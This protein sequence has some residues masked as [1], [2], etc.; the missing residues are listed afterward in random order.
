[1]SFLNDINKNILNIME[2]KEGGKER[3]NSHWEIN[4]FLTARQRTEK[5]SSI[6]FQAV[7][8]VPHSILRKI[9]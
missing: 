2:Y 6:V 3:I 9:L 1:M 5:V 4:I 8:I 7:S